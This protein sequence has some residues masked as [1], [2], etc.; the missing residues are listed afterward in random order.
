MLLSIVQL[1]LRQKFPATVSW[2]GAP[3]AAFA[4]AVAAQRGAR[5]MPVGVER[6]QLQGG[7]RNGGSNGSGAAAMGPN[8]APVCCVQ[9]LILLLTVPTQK[10]T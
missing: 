5:S 3:G 4:A 9:A 7:A 2:P 8:G 10:I 1:L 6:G